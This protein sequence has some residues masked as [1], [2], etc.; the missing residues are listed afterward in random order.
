MTRESPSAAEK[1]GD[2]LIGCR[3]LCRHQVLEIEIGMHHARHR[4]VLGGMVPV[5]A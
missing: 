3:A 1:I 5:G 4:L 2:S